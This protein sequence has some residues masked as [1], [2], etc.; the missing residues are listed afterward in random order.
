[1]QTPKKTNR[2]VL[3]ALRELE[4]GKTLTYPAERTSYIR[5]VCVSYGLE[6][7]KKFKTAVNRQQ[8]TITVTRTA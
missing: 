3:P 1:M 6:W 2:P 5:S 8:R 4:I 7:Q